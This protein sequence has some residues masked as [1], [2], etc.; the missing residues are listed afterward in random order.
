MASSLRIKG[1][2]ID[3]IRFIVHIIKNSKSQKYASIKRK[4]EKATYD[5]SCKVI[6]TYDIKNCLAIINSYSNSSIYEAIKQS[7]GILDLSNEVS[8]YRSLSFPYL[9]DIIYHKIHAEFYNYKT[10]FISKEGTI[11]CSICLDVIDK[12]LHV[13]KCNHTFHN[14]CYFKYIKHKNNTTCPN[15]RQYLFC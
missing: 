4:I 1:C 11:E 8:F 14:L 3:E 7:N 6:N 12:E 15:C 10:N 9:Y 2:K 5:F 13:T